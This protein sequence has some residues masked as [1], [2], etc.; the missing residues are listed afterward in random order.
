MITRNGEED[1]I[2]RAGVHQTH[3]LGEVLLRYV[4]QNVHAIRKVGIKHADVVDSEPEAEE[5]VIRGP[6]AVVRAFLEILD[7][8]IGLI[9]ETLYLGTVRCNDGAVDCRSVV[10]KIIR[11]CDTGVEVTKQLTDPVQTARRGS[12]RK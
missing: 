7:P 5:T 6:L 1:K 4:L 3:N 11:Y 2:P 9:N 8:G 10:G 12:A